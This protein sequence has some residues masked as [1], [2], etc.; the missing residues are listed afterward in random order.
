[1][2]FSLKLLGGVA[3]TGPEGGL[4]TAAMQRHR[5]ALLAHLAVAAPRSVSRDKL[6]ALLWPERDDEHSRGLLNQAV[7]ALRQSL[8]AQALTTEG[9]DLRLD[10]ALIRTDVVGFREA[11]A[12][13]ETARAVAL[14]SGPLLD[15]FFLDD[16][17]EFE[18]W[19]DRERA[20]L[21]AEYVRVLEGLAESAAHD[22]AWDLAADRW[23]AR[24]DHDPLDSRVAL[25]LIEAL[26]RTGNRAGA[27]QQ[28]HKHQQQLR[29]EL[30]IA[31]S[32]EIAAAIQR[33]RRAPGQ[34]GAVS[35]PGD[36]PL[37]SEPVVEG[38]GAAA[39]PL[40]TAP[41]DVRPAASSRRTRTLAIVVVVVLMVGLVW[42]G[43]GQRTGTVAATP[44]VVD[45]IAQ[46]VAAELDRRGRGDSTAPTLEQRTAN[47]AA[48]ELYLRGN[49]PILLRSD[50]AAR[51]RSVSSASSHRPLAINARAISAV[52]EGESGSMATARCAS[53]S[54]SEGR[55]EKI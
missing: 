39:Q 21:A 29:A 23:Q 52:A 43:A 5:V 1:M 50:S 10:T 2:S 54:A 49:D 30:G 6:I 45:E 11:I 31:A 48:Y 24:A 46:A 9:N 25:R 53:T 33:L 22:G 13:G 27:L 47:I 12:A 51:G 32:P 35:P 37:I 18:R 16:S 4:V 42:W 3:L 55:P 28:A 8:G 17:P 36:A 44:K 41:D 14:Y 7:Y 34:T 15:G 19:L 20:R 26:E 38:Q 40:P